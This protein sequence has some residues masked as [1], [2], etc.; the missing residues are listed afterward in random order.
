MLRRYEQLCAAY[1]TVLNANPN[2]YIPEPTSLYDWAYNDFPE[3]WN[4]R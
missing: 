3:K 1:H 2:A 4:N